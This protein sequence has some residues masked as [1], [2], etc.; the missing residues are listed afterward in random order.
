MKVICGRVNDGEDIV[1]P[2]A[3]P[4][5]PDGPGAAEGLAAQ[6]QGP[7]VSG[8]PWAATP[9]PRVR[10]AGEARLGRPGPARYTVRVVPC[11]PLLDGAPSWAWS[12]TQT[13]RRG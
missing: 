6:P 12:P 3:S 1:E 10:Y 5:A 9:G 11:H 13:L 2:E 8:T 4:L 7:E